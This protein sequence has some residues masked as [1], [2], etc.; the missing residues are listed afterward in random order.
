MLQFMFKRRKLFD[1]SLS[2]FPLDFVRG[3]FYR[4]IHVIQGPGLSHTS[5]EPSIMEAFLTIITGHRSL[6]EIYA[7]EFLSEVEEG[8]LKVSLAPNVKGFL[9]N[10]GIVL[11]GVVF[12][13]RSDQWQN[14]GLQPRQKV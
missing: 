11:H 1:D 13:G 10:L 9:T 5:A 2:L 7:K 14:Y 8:A 6:A 3:V 4:F 12:V